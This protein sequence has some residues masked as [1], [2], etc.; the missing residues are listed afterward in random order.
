MGQELGGFSVGLAAHEHMERRC[1]MILLNSSSYLKQI[2]PQYVLDLAKY[3]SAKEHTSKI[4]NQFTGASK[5][6]H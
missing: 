5:Y 2:I 1:A 6:T 4:I 3:L